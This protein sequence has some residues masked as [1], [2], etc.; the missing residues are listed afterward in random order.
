M[1]FSYCTNV[2]RGE[3]WAEVWQSLRTHVPGVRRAL[4]RAPSDPFP[5]GLRL[6]AKATTELSEDRALLRQLRGWMEEENL[7][8]YTINGF[9]YGAFHG[10]R[11]KEQVFAPDWSRPE[12][13][14][15]TQQLFELL[16]ELLP[17]GAEGSV[18]TV[19]GSFKEFVAAEPDRKPAIIAALR[20]F[21]REI[22]TLCHAKH[23]DLH[24]G[25]EP[26]PL[27]LLENSADTFAFFDALTDGLS[28]SEAEM[29]LRRIGVCYDACHFAI[30]YEDAATALEGLCNAGIRLSK[31]HLSNALALDPRNPE[32][33]LRVRQFQEPVYL[34]QVAARHQDGTIHRFRDLPD[35]LT[36]LANPHTPAAVEWRVHFHIP[37][38]AQPDAPMDSTVSHLHSMST[39]LAKNAGRCRHFEMETYTF[40]VLPAALRQASAEEM[41]A[42][43]FRWCESA[44][45][46]PQPGI[47]A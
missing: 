23:L 47:S 14:T 29:L 46:F 25:L 16:Q 30:A 7:V 27:G 10:T 6:G 20:R 1:H 42:E 43:E 34:H 2:H 11:V 31:I 44:I 26:E 24:L 8:A 22:D 33:I 39:W 45:F 3:S 36:D 4:H 12:R 13:F 35:A 9:P 19:P 41:I 28:A 17:E 37:L 32:A 5:L 21:A 40:D 15:Y 18:S 38:Y